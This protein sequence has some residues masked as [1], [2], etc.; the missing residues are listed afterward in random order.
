MALYKLG[1][2]ETVMET[3]IDKP[4]YLEKKRNFMIKKFG[5]LKALILLTYQRH[6]LLKRLLKFKKLTEVAKAILAE[7]I[8]S[9]LP[10]D[11]IYEIPEFNVYR[12]LLI[13][14]NKN[15]FN[16][17]LTQGRQ[18]NYICNHI[19][20]CGNKV[21]KTE[22]EN[23]FHLCKRHLAYRYEKEMILKEFFKPIL[24]NNSVDIIIKYSMGI[25]FD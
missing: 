24:C 11:I 20:R 9:S 23:G 15:C 13:Q 21:C 1:S 22:T 8:F 7:K 2:L 3:K 6:K 5:K 16:S 17:F 19:E 10:I 25:A 14:I 4:F 18:L 12:K